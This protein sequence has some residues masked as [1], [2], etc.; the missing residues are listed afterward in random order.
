MDRTR[1]TV[2]IIEDD[3]SVRRSLLRLMRSAG[4]NA[5]G[6]ATAEEFLQ[7]SGLAVPGCLLLDVH[8][9]GMSGLELQELLLSEGRQVPVVF[10]TAYVDERVRERALRAGAVAFLQKPFEEQALLDAVARALGVS[11]ING[12]DPGEGQTPGDC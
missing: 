7:F 6:F 1:Q 4:R 10:I 8:L 12:P 9:P 3:D 2:F 5:Q 11:P